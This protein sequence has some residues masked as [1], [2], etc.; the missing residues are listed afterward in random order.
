MNANVSA[1]FCFGDVTG[2]RIP[3]EIIMESE[4]SISRSWDMGMAV[5]LLMMLVE[6]QRSPDGASKLRTEGMYMLHIH[7]Q[8]AMSG[9]DMSSRIR[10][11]LL[12]EL[13]KDELFFCVG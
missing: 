13:Q 2:E 9:R 4:S 10:R 11:K 7:E 8:M 12:S 1:L 5:K 6:I 3:E